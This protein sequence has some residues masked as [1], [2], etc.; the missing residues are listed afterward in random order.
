MTNP[1]Y[2]RQPDTISLEEANEI[3]KDPSNQKQ[4][5]NQFSALVAYLQEHVELLKTRSKDQN[6]LAWFQPSYEQSLKLNAWLYGIDYIVDFDA[7]R[8]G[9]TAGAVVN[10]LLWVLPNDP[11]WIMF[12]PFTDH[13]ARTYQVIKRP[14]ISLL[15]PIRDNLK[16]L[17]HTTNPRLPFDDPQNLS[18]YLA[19]IRLINHLPNPK[20]IY[21]R[22]YKTRLWVGGPDN[23]WNTKNI[24]PEFLKWTPKNNI[25]SFSQY[26]KTLILEYPTPN[27]VH[28]TATVE[29]SFKSYD[30]EDTK[31]SGGAVDGIVLSEGLPQSIFNEVKQR[32]LYP[33]FSSW[34]YT[35]YEARNTGGKSALAHRVFNGEEPLPLHPYVYSGF[36]I[37]DT[38]DYI[39]DPDKRA[40]LIR[41]WHGKP[42]GDA[43]IKGIFYTSSPLVLKNYRPD[44]HCLPYSLEELRARYAP[45]PLILFRGVDPGWGHLTVCA[46]MALAPDNTK[47][48]YR[49][50]AES[51]LSIEERCTNIILL[52]GNKRVKHPKDPRRFYE[53]VSDP[54]NRIQSTFIDYHAFKTDEI[55]K[56][57]FANNYI[58][59]GLSVRA[60]ST[61]GPKER[62]MLL[63]DMLL[64]QMHLPHPV[65]K[66]APGS[67]IYFLTVEPGVATALQKMQNVFY[68]SYTVGEKRGRTKDEIQ[69][70]DD[71]ELDAVTYVALP[72]VSYN[73]YIKKLPDVPTMQESLSHQKFSNV[74]FVR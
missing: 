3:I 51:Q 29:I 48:I 65:T 17:N 39:M 6:P 73:S 30:S 59:N 55:T 7:N 69:D 49:V 36:G 37:E 53:H 8:I 44:F 14:P 70:Y 63:N 19:T 21:V 28:H 16:K 61:H 68:Q 67:P 71:D 52:S 4:F 26:T 33:A 32:F 46:W 23:E 11:T 22:K 24:I 66:I 50:Y 1:W 41:N 27:P 38:P 64:P 20:H 60:S 31:W 12:R 45:Q 57:P 40:D 15:R 25:R 72:S 62:A 18:A 54:D 10:T 42:E 9:K 43:R 56:Q 5:P 35:P 47:Y 2:Q 58:R 34:D 74:Q 13:R